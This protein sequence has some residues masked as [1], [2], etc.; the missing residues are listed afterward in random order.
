MASPFLSLSLISIIDI[1]QIETMF[2]EITLASFSDV[3]LLYASEKEILAKLAPN[4]T[5]KA[6]FPSATE[7]QNV[8]LV[9][10]VFNELTLAAPKLQ[11]ELSNREY[12][13]NTHDFVEILLQLW[14]LFNINSPLKGKHMNNDMSR[15]LTYQDER[16]SLLACVVIWLETWLALPG[17]V[18]KLSKP[19]V[20]QL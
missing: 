8:K 11:N 17:N 1:R 16:F 19:N 5:I 15:P 12:R 3:R 9:L 7:R 20:H 4:L 10:K 6:C 13:N 2:T 14:K 18:G